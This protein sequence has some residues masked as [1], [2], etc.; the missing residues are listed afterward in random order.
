MIIPNFNHF[1][2]QSLCVL[3]ALSKHRE[4]FFSIIR[5]PVLQTT[6]QNHCAPGF[7]GTV[8]ANLKAVL[9]CSKF[10]LSRISMEYKGT[11]DFFRTFVSLRTLFLRQFLVWTN[12]TL[13]LEFVN[14][15]YARDCARRT[16]LFSSKLF[17]APQRKPKGRRTRNGE[18]AL[19]VIPNFAT[20]KDRFTCNKKLTPLPVT[21]NALHTCRLHS[22]AFV[23]KRNSWTRVN[24]K[25]SYRSTKKT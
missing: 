21:M 11:V 25:S 24:K 9:S 20:K 22:P 15:R 3:Y 23:A 5:K 19:E 18:V 7:S 6:I 4:T 13:L 2:F 1:S 17:S 8:S 10:S 12:F 14:R 16:R